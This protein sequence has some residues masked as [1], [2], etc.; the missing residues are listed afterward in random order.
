MKKVTNFIKTAL[1]EIKLKSFKHQQELVLVT[2]SSSSHFKSLHQFLESIHIFEPNTKTVVYDLGLKD[3][4]RDTLLSD[5]KNIDLRKFDFEKYPDHV[6][7][8]VNDGEYAWK[9]I[10]IDTVLNEFKC[11]IC[12]L[13]AGNVLIE[14][15]ETLRKLIE[16]FG[17]YSPYSK[18]IIKDWTHQN[19]LKHLQ[20]DNN[21]ELLQQTN[22]NGACI[23]ADYNNLTI[24]KIITEWKD[25]ALDKNCIA[26]K[27]ATKKNHRYDQA[28]LSTLIYKHLP[29][30]GKK[31]TYKKFGF[32]I[33]QDIDD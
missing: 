16:Y 2:G 12:W 26:P 5:F 1:L 21:T 7:I 15:L 13:D 11:S 14:K 32:K 24:R 9:P 29:E 18:G 33:H 3:I 22:L 6:N 20:V 31:M 8:H 27:G 25:C 28:I 23:S 10:I 4:E 19:S 30:L 17:F